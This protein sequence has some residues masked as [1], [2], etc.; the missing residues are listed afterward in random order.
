MSKYTRVFTIS[1]E[2][3]LVYRMNFIMWRFRNVIQV[4]LVFFLWDA[5][6][7]NPSTEVFGYTRDQMLS[8]V[9]GLLIV[10]GLVLSARS[11][12]VSGEI[13]RG[14]LSNYL[15]KPVSYFKYWLTRDISSKSLNLVF[16]IFETAILFIIL[17]PPLFIQTNPTAI[18][19]AIIAILFAMAIYFL[20]LFI[21][22]AIPFWAPEAAWGVH[23]VITIV[24]VEFLSG[25]LFPLD[26][27]PP[28]I[29][30][31]L[32]FTPF[33]YL[34][35]FPLE[36]YLGKIVGLEIIKGLFI[37]GAWIVIMWF[38]MNKIWNRGLKLYQGHGR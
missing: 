1:M 31:V 5:I 21:I 37:S 17:K 19:G 22:G 3:E 7:A 8:Y 28:Q 6:F 11:M 30:T 18:A 15:I 38:F 12:E 20:L 16:A 9:F 33:P 34:I 4:I 10:R 25:A 13:S 2:H 27:L 24:L 14:D 32:S 26:V 29:L 35:F 23:F 36:I